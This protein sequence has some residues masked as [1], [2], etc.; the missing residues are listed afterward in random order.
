MTVAASFEIAAGMPQARGTQVAPGT[1][2]EFGSGGAPGA[3]KLV[4]APGTAGGN[5]TAGL[6]VSSTSNGIA[7]PE[8]F[9]SKWQQMV[10]ALDD[11]AD[12]SGAAEVCTSQA[13]ATEDRTVSAL[14]HGKQA[15]I[16]PDS[17]ALQ[18]SD[19]LSPQTPTTLARAVA[20]AQ[21][22]EG[23]E[24]QG[25]PLSGTVLLAALSGHMKSNVADR[26]V[27]EK[28]QKLQENLPSPNDVPA[29]NLAQFFQPVQQAMSAKKLVSS[30]AP[31]DTVLPSNA[32]IG[33][34]T[35]KSPVSPEPHD[36]ISNSVVRVSAAPV[37]ETET[38]AQGAIDQLAEASVSG[39]DQ[40]PAL[41][42]AVANHAPEKTMESPF[43]APAD[44]VSSV[45]AT[46][47][48]RTSGAGQVQPIAKSDGS[49][50]IVSS[51]SPSPAA[52][53]ER[54]QFATAR[55]V[56]GARSVRANNGDN[57]QQHSAA[58][59]GMHS[60]L[61]DAIAGVAAARDTAPAMPSNTGPGP[62][63]AATAGAHTAETFTALDGAGSSMQSTWF[64]A[65]AHQA[66]AGFEDPA[67]GWVSV[68]AGVNAGG[69]SAVVVPGSADATQALGAHMAGLHDFLAEQRSPV[70]SLTLAQNSGG[71][72]GLS[73]SMQH[74]GQ[75]QPAQDNPASTQTSGS[76]PHFATVAT[77]ERAT[78]LT[79]SEGQPGAP[80]SGGRY[81][82][83]MA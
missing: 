79:G 12:E 29:M 2:K 35:A 10:A 56:A 65:G 24:I 17:Q 82:S 42:A 20:V 45:S 67:L 77:P 41:N 4:G 15:P 21:Q 78:Q 34:F 14:L 28:S 8:S 73:Q 25:A 36:P 11:T 38:I 5:G 23:P 61:N 81:I 54:P 50:G 58:V 39:A 83:V 80:G 48:L 40:V 68:R 19:N 26:P 43:A 69:I 72:A 44:S 32:Q 51:V 30:A 60:Q 71:D 16:D 64:H 70:E 7:A 3:H 46:S 52:E 53:V 57:A 31:V 63:V 55:D 74:Q 1:V 9:R 49:D 37:Q 62:A 18:A 22:T 27:F 13:G 66:E 47:Q 75:H 59:E 33:A 6:K 76:V